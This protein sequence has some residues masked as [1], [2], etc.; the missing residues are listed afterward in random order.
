MRTEKEIKEKL[1][2]LETSFKETSTDA[3]FVSGVE[4][5]LRYVLGYRELKSSLLN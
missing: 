3:S 2:E 1:A 4:T 5:A